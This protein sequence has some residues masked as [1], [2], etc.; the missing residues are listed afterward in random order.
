MATVAQRV[1]VPVERLDV[2]AYTVPTDRRESDGT[3]EWDSTT[4]VVVEIAAGGE[5]GLGYT[6][7]ET[8]LPLITLEPSPLRREPGGG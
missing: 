6:D 3:L 5:R 1:D 2:S 4:L 7:E 8:G